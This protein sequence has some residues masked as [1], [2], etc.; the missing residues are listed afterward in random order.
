MVITRDLVI[1]IDLVVTI[2]LVIT[3]FFIHFA[4]VTSSNKCPVSRFW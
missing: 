1:T 3:I 4:F 2:D